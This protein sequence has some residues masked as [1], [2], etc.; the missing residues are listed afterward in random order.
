M[1][2]FMLYTTPNLPYCHTFDNQSA[3][4]Q[5]EIY[6]QYP[7]KYI[8]KL[9]LIL[10]NTKNVIEERVTIRSQSISRTNRMVSQET[11]AEIGRKDRII[12]SEKAPQE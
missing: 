2:Y 11:C 5:L 8:L 9:A 1:L 10:I 4:N 6:G 12:I 3:S 7:I